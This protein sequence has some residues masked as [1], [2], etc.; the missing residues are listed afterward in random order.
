MQDLPDSVFEEAG[1]NGHTRT[2]SLWYIA[3]RPEYTPTQYTYKPY[4][5]SS[6]W[7]AKDAPVSRE[8]V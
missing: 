6:T 1:G 8:T 5:E 2:N 7:P 3:T 4:P